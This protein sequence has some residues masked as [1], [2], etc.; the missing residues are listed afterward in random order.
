MADW[1]PHPGGHLISSGSSPSAHNAVMG[2]GAVAWCAAT[3]LSWLDGAACRGSRPCWQGFLVLP[4]VGERL[5]L[6]RPARRSDLIVPSGDAAGGDY[7]VRLRLSWFRSSPS[8]SRTSGSQGVGAASPQAVV[9]GALRRRPAHGAGTG[10]VT[11]FMADGVARPGTCGFACAG[12]AG[13]VYAALSDGGPAL[14]RPR[15]TPC[16]SGS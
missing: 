2:L 7:G 4:I 11:R 14:R 15:C 8:R 16:S 3:V 12:V 13:T 9:A 10:G 1:P 6:A 5:E